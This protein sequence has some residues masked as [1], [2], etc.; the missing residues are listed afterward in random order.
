M[1]TKIDT[2]NWE[3]F[4]IGDIFQKL[5]LKV[6][7]KDFNK[8][9]DVSETKTAEFSLPLVNAKHGNNGIMYYGRPCDFESAEMTIDVVQNGA[10]AT[11]D[12]YAQPQRTGVLWD[13]YLLKP[14]ADIS[15]EKVLLF[16]ATVLEKSIKKNFSYDDKCT[17]KRVKELTIK[18]PVNSNHQPDY[19]Y[20]DM[21]MQSLE[22]SL[23]ERLDHLKS[24]VDVPYY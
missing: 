6:T 18:L 17:W 11:G 3:H 23:K 8:K 24:L 7:K 21:Y 19:A 1:M 12:V 13:A 5:D 20:M 16:L 2:T 14:T 4:K 10:I 9:I 15:S 22:I